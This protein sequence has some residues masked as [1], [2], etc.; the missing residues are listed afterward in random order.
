LEIDNFFCDFFV[1]WSGEFG[2]SLDMAQQ[3][4]VFNFIFC[5][6]GLLPSIFP[7]NAQV[8]VVRSRG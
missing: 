6:E 8:F 4:R 1:V 2:P 7:L 3:A 5:R